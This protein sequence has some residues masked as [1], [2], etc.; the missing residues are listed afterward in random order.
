MAITAI[1]ILRYVYYLYTV[2]NDTPELIIV[3]TTKERTYIL[4][5]VC[6]WCTFEKKRNATQRVRNSTIFI[7]N[8]SA[9]A[10]FPHLLSPFVRSSHPAATRRACFPSARTQS[11][12]TTTRGSAL[13]HA[14]ED[15]GAAVRRCNGAHDGEVHL[16]APS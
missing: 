9:A 7:F 4:V 3:C 10:V 15:R 16:T 5:H 6:T 13:D 11:R 2:R 12:G 8:T 1:N 14:A